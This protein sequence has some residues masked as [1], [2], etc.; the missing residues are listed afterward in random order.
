MAK[1]IMIQGTMS[2]SGKS[3]LAAALY[4]TAPFKSQNMALNSYITDD[5]LEIG[6]AQAMQAEAAGISPT[7]EMNPI[8]LKPTSHMGSQVVIMGEV[9]GN[10]KAMDYYRRKPELVP[11]IKDAFSRLEEQYEVIVLEG[12]GSPAE[13]NL[14]E[15]D[16]VNMG[17]AEMADAPVLLVGDIDRGGVFASL[18]GTVKLLSPQEQKRIRGLIINKFRGDKEILKPGLSMLYERCPI[19]VAGVVPYMDV[20]LDD[21]DS[22]ADRLWAKDTA[23]D[24]NGRKAFARIAVVRLPRISNFT[25]FNALE[26]LPGVALYYA[27]RPEE[28]SAAD[29]VILPGT[30]NTMGD[31]KWIRETGMEAAILRKYGEGCFVFGVCGGFQMLGMRLSDPFGIEEGGTLR[32]LGLLPVETVFSREKT[33]TR[34]TGNAWVFEEWGG[35]A[36]PGITGYEIHMGETK[37]AGGRPCTGIRKETDPAGAVLKEDG[38][39]Q[40]RAAGT[41]VHGFFDSQEIQRAVWELLAG[42]YGISMDKLPKAG[43]FSMAAHKE[44]Q[45]KKLAGILRENL[46]M[47]RIYGILDRRL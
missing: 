45:Y 31:L 4:R 21:E 28:L 40:G 18:Y 5:G 20:D 24:R 22:L 8:L 37:R 23:M 33:R 35:A 29:L 2:N 38:C 1:K 36:D 25:D 12:A 26:H 19:P 6:R 11:V 17:M 14:R 16:I 41:Y 10:M 42:K 13:I 7:A 15:N 27:D 39:I 3:F 47:D 32:G 9:F 44:E 43:E 46:D 34:V 30:K